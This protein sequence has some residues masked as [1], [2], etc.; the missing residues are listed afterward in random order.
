MSS[1]QSGKIV[2]GLTGPFGSGCS[3]LADVLKEKYS[4]ISYSLSDF[5]KEAW[6]IK[7]PGKNIKDAPREELQAIG[8][9]IRREKGLHALAEMAFEL[10]EKNNKLEERLVFDSIRNIAEIEFLRK[11]FHNFC[12]IALD[13]AENHR[14]LRTQELYKG[15]Y[16]AFSNDDNRDK[17]EEGLEYGQ[18]VALCVDDADILIRNDTDDMIRTK[19]AWKERLSIRINKYMK[20]FEG[21]LQLPNEQETFMSMAYTASLKSHCFK[22]QV[23]AVI[24][25]LMGKVVSVGYNDNPASLQS[26]IDGFYGCFR[27]AYMD[28]LM[29]VLKFCPECG[30]QLIDFKYPYECPGCQKNVCRQVIR[31]RALGRCSALHAEE[32]ALL[33]S[34]RQNLIGCTLY[35]TAFPCFTCTQKILDMGISTIWYAESYP[36]ADGLRAFEKAGTVS[37]QKFEGVKA[38]AY[39][40]LFPQWRAQQEK[41]M[42]ARRMKQWTT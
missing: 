17:N 41:I 30:K 6:L 24:V 39:F 4:Y 3:T 35:V 34:G 27:D 12:L 5:V 15:N 42:L 1:L 31:D 2:L 36:D 11:K 7:N 10:A 26:C 32:R 22:R 8:N 33:D 37:L 23:G 25:D 20:I 21:D 19:S 28:E 38:R 16:W 14:W 29:K 18:Q 9:N 13:C 40:R